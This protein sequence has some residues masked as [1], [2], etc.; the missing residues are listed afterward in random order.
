MMNFKPQDYP[1]CSG[2]YLMKN[3]RG[4]II[5]V[6]KAK[7]LR[8]RLA[9]YFRPQELLAL[10]TQVMMSKV[11]KID[12]LC[13]DTEKEAF[14]LEDSLI[15]KHRPRYNIVLRDDKSYVLFK[16]DKKADYPRL[17][18]TRQVVQ[19]GSVYFGP[20]TSALGAR[21]T[22]KVVNR[23]FSLRKCKDSAFKNRVRPCLQYN[24]GRCL[25]PCVRS[26][27]EDD[28]QQVVRKVELFL[29]GRSSELIRQLKGEMQAAAENLEFEH[30]A[31]LRDQL[32]AI[33]QTVEKQAVVLT[34]EK[35]RDVLG[36]AY[37]SEGVALSIL[38]IR[39]GRL[40][41]KKTFF[42]ENEEL[43]GTDIE[44]I[45]TATDIKS[46]TTVQQVVGEETYGEDYELIRSFLLQFYRAGRFIP[47]KIILPFRLE[48]PVLEEILSERGGRQ[49]QLASAWSKEEKKLVLLSEQNAAQGGKG[50]A[51]ELNTG[52]NLKK[53][54]HLT[55]EPERIESV[56]AS[57][58]SGKGI[59]V[60]Q[61]VFENEQAKKNDYRLYK[62]PELED[63][64]DD[65]AALSAWVR[66]RIKSGPP[67]PDLVLIDGGKGQ[68][69]AVERTLQEEKD[70]IL[71][72]SQDGK[73]DRS[74]YWELAAI[75][76]GERR[77]GELEERIFRPGRKNP[78]N[79][80][81]GSP[82]LLFLQHMRDCAHRFV[83]SRQRRSR[84]KSVQQGTLESLPGIGPKTAAI[85]WQ[86]F[87]SLEK[88]LDASV[89]ELQELPGLGKKRAEQVYE[90]MQKQLLRPKIES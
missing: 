21:E 71:N 54:L 53:A 19:D 5:Y 70:K 80:K 87:S 78:L 28:Y 2:V 55:K 60:G 35:D 23:L 11:C 84:K 67:W 38:F 89:E 31:K 64:F 65:Y 51:E 43:N 39:Q 81:S 47:E 1:C 26:V 79:L 72:N 15:K 14:L 76:K 30:A 88:M 90:V 44:N 69:A 52:C 61:V 63:S 73:E 46:N 29:S 3:E 32:K 24:I 48:D 40:L 33:Q 12:T 42:W 36:L 25:A 74:A 45:R 50:S 27:A 83:L 9:S 86:H 58:L 34:D 56:D 7:V 17:S 8:K 37:L 82:E 68:L 59:V 85:L 62:F 57:H 13:T 4:K 75:A 20:F 66:R 6:G 22:W 10:K 77:A 16:L 49:V 41:D 18:I